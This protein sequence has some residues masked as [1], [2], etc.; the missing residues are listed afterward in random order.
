MALLNIRH[1]NKPSFSQI[2]VVLHTSHNTQTVISEE[3]LLAFECKYLPPKLFIFV[4]KTSLKTSL[5]TNIIIERY[6]YVITIYI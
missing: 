5:N 3:S 6:V 4:E 2:L 1:C